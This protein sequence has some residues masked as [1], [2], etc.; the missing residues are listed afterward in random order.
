MTGAKHR[1]AFTLI[2]LLI[3]AAV[4][5]LT[6]LLA[7]T[8]FSNIQ[9]TQR[10]ISGQQ[11]VTSDG[12]YVLE[13]IAQSIRTGSVNYLRENA[14]G[15][16]SYVLT[17]P[18]VDST[19]SLIDQ[20]G[21]ITCYRLN[22]LTGKVEVLSGGTTACAPQ[23]TATWVPFT[24]D[25]LNVVDLKFYISPVSDPSRPIPRSGSDCKV[26]TSTDINGVVVSGFDVAKGA[27]VCLAPGIDAV[28]CFTGQSCTTSGTVKTCTN[29]NVQPQVTMY[30]KSQ[31]RTG[32]AGEQSQIS[33]QTTVVTR[34]YQR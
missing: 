27:C 18:A 7:T 22:A 26:A 31:S 32:A 11:R 14:S 19:L 4:F 13:T 6:A 23:G 34:I 3:V 15:A 16:S 33:L 1:Q 21:L 28:N 10:G 12:R 20:V 24:P 9:S 8:V 2:E 17:S 30:I 5:A 29:P 25:D